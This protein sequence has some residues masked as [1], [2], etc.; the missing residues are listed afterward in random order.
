MPASGWYLFDT[1]GIFTDDRK[2]LSNAYCNWDHFGELIVL[3]YAWITGRSWY[4][5]LASWI[6]KI[7]GQAPEWSNHFDKPFKLMGFDA[8]VHKVE[9]E[10]S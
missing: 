2:L 6:F 10:S 8:K 4:K 9:L 7:T 1:G 5:R 3:P